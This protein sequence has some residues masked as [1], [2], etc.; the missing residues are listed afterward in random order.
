MVN[1]SKKIF[2]LP[3]N[4]GYGVDSNPDQILI[5]FHEKRSG[6]HIH[7]SIVGNVVTPKGYGS[8]DVCLKISEHSAWKDLANAIKR[9][10]S[11]AGI[12]LSSAW[13]GYR[14]IMNFVSKGRQLEDYKNK[15][16][17]IEESEIESIFLDFKHGIDLSIEHGFGHI[18]IHAAHGYLISLL[19]DSNFC[20]KYE[21]ARVRLSELVDYI[22]IKKCESSIRLSM[23][24]GVQSIDKFRSNDIKEILKIRASYF[25][26]SSGFYNINKNLIYPQTD[27]MLKSRFIDSVRICKE[28]KQK[29]FILSGKSLQKFHQELPENARIGVC[30]D[31][32]ANPNFL[33]GHNEGCKNKKKCHYH[34]NGTKNLYCGSW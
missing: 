32:I 24:T 27:S 6:P 3:V 22:N 11:I 2:F 21:L 5:E 9:K 12:Q 19:I 4:T 13:A 30:R 25:D 28:H 7:A 34:S 1:E 14:G 8:N 23:R 29:S 31:L 17:S 16:S 18:Q 20:D 10:G 15:F 33:L 26:L